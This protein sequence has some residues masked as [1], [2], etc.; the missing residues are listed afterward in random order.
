[1]T[2]NG[3]RWRWTFFSVQLVSLLLLGASAVQAQQVASISGEIR[4]LNGGFPNERLEVTLENHG[5]VVGVTYS[6]SEGRFSFTGVLPNSYSVVIQAQGYLP[7]RQTVVVNPE[8]IQS[9]FVHIVLRPDTNAR[10]PGGPGGFAGGNSDVVSVAD[11]AKKYPPEVKKE[12]EAGQKAE[13]NGDIAAAI[14]HYRAALRLAPDFYQAHN[15]LGGAYTKKGD[16]KS[17]EQELR[18]ALQLNP[19]SAQADFNLGNVLYL[20]NRNAEAKKLLEEGLRHAPASA[21][22]RYFLGCVLTRLREFAPAEEQL[23]SARQLDPKLP[24]V[25]IAL[26]TLYLQTGRQPE[27]IQMFEDFLRQFPESPL[28]PKVRAAV[29]KLSR[30]SSPPPASR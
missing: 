27:A 14:E 28:A 17:A 23:K 19:N 6:D 1:M 26:A 5:S 15:N 4:L 8:I 3:E 11:L 21:M 12:F 13:A 24:Q 7:V 2:V 18:R 9:T 25:P 29:D 10:S 30:Q 16:L 20:T 22:G